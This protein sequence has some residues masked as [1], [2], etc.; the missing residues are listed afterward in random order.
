PTV[1][2]SEASESGEVHVPFSFSLLPGLSTSGLRTGN[3]VN[4]IS[5]GLV[6]THAKRVEGVALALGA[7]W[8]D[9]RLSGAQLAV[10]ANVSKGPVS[11]GQFAV[12]GNVSGGDLFGMQYAVGANVVRGMMEGAQFGVGGNLVAGAVRGVQAGVGVNVATSGLLGAQLAV[13]A[14]IAAGP[15]RGLQATSGINIAGELT[16]AQLSSGI[17]YARHLSGA[18]LSLL[19]VVGAVEGA[20]VGLINVAGT[21]KGAQL[22]LLNFAG[23]TEGEA[24]GLLSFVGNGQHHVQVWASD[25][26]L[27]NVGL[28]LGGRHLYTLLTAGYTPAR[29][30]ERYRYTLGAGFGGHIPVGRFFVDI[31]V[32]GSNLH[33]GSLFGEASQHILGQLRLMGGV[34]L[35]RRFALFAGVSANTLVTWDSSDRWDDVGLGPQWREFADGGT[36]TVRTWPGL[37]AGIQL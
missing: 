34:Q 12:G 22:G 14:N 11:G 26:S 3:V 19:N 36:T 35:A 18:Q 1:K 4:N 29:A 24:V 9:E 17:S 20:Q 33:S 32:L 28:K 21:V 27:T 13:G 6:A 15:S 7:N 25:V 37:L 31:D 2:A 16:G 8:V 10:G 30:G 5:I 23:H